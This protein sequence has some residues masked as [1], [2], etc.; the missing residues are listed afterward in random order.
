MVALFRLPSGS[1]LMLFLLRG[2]TLR[3]RRFAHLLCVCDSEE[4]RKS[5][6]ERSE[7]GAPASV[8]DKLLASCRKA[9]PISQR[10]TGASTKRIWNRVKP[11]QCG[12]ALLVARMVTSMFFGHAR[13]LVEKQTCA[14]LRL[15]RFGEGHSLLR[16]PTLRERENE[17]VSLYTR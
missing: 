12:S 14:M 8:V 15:E 5:T 13:E 10:R 7:A 3:I 11:W 1:K 17:S 16:P 4:E 6:V 9:F 2:T